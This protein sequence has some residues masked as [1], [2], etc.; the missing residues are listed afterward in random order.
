MKSTW[1]PVTLAAFALGSG[2]FAQAQIN[3]TG[4]HKADEDS[5]MVQSLDISVGDVEDMTIYSSGGDEV[6]E[7]E[8]VLVDGSGQP[9]AIAADVGGFLDLG[10]R[11]V[12]IGLDRLSKGQ[13]RLT[14]A[15]SKEEIEALPEF[16]EDD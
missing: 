5:L 9:V 7:V 10:E 11:N 12:V 8:A 1:L 2:S 4:L 3:Q 14:V 13:D 6:G 16:A 15:M